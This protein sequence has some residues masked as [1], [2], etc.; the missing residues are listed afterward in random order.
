MTNYE[1]NPLAYIIATFIISFVI[2]THIIWKY[3]NR[4][5]FPLFTYFTVFMQYFCAFSIIL[6]V[7]L[8]LALTISA[9]NSEINKQYYEKNY[10]LI[11]NTYLALYWISTILSNFVL[12][13]EEQYNSNGFFTTVSKLRNTCKKLFLSTL[14]LFVVCGIFFIILIFTNTVK[15]NFDAIFLTSILITNTIWMMFLMLLLGYGLIMYP[16]DV[17]KRGNYQAR[18]NKTQM[19][20]ALEFENVA[21]AYVELFVCISNIYQTK[22]EI[23]NNYSTNQNL[24]NA[25]L[26]YTIEIL[27]SNCPIC[28]ISSVNAENNQTSGNIIYNKLTG[29]TT[30]G[31]LANYAE[32]MY[33]SNSKFTMSQG[34]LNK[35]QSKAYFLED[36]IDSVGITSDID[37][38][39]NNGTHK[40][41]KWSF[42]PSSTYIEYLW[43]IYVKPV[44]YKII[45][46]IYGFLSVCS[47]LGVIV[48]IKGIPPKFSPYFAIVHSK[49]SAQLITIFVFVTIGYVCN[50]AKWALFETYTFRSFRLIGNK[51]TWPIPMSINARMFASIGIPLIFFYLGWLRE[52]DIIG[53]D[54]ELDKANKQLITIFAKFYQMKA[55]PIAGNSFNAFF[56]ILMLVISILVTVNYL[57]KLLV[58]I[59]C[60]GLQFGLDN[61]EE[62]IL[63]RGN[64]KLHE[65]K[66][67]LKNAYIN[68][69]KQSNQSKKCD[70]ENFKTF[71]S[72]F[73]QQSKF[74]FDDGMI[75]IDSGLD[76]GFNLENSDNLNNLDSESG[77]NLQP[78]LN[79]V[80]NCHKKIS[81][82][83]VLIG[84]KVGFFSDMFKKY[85][86]KP[87]NCDTV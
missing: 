19:E 76:N 21:N 55:I 42:K 68:M 10:N 69:I 5:V 25:N 37:L 16:I 17:W 18:L 53:G 7:P 80:N 24:E 57:N 78:T 31:S 75:M 26:L 1:I 49:I 8:D 20:L 64:L 61:I 59:H 72:G 54:F 32:Q 39:L 66:K 48:S 86:I 29:T 22:K 79:F 28:P 84:K 70:N 74:H 58:I 50:V 87:S 9:R 73:K 46:V 40:S 56:P 15:S 27:M 62:N 23:M 52:N 47:Y 71:L 34:A 45:A 12:T 38:H 41:I 51:V 82:D 63:E 2:S 36:L 77:F 85:G 30:I 4:K 81:P 83:L 33:F 3:A 13:F 14:L 60:S 11:F 44:I 6:I 65:R 35:L 67:L 43:Y